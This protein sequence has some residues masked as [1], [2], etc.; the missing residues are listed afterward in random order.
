MKERKSISIDRKDLETLKPF[1]ASSGD[2]LS[3]AIR[4]LIEHYRSANRIS[5]VTGDQQR[6]M[7]LRNQI[8]EERIAVLVPVPLIKWLLRR[9]PGVPPLGTFRVLMEK[10]TR[11]LGKDSLSLRDYIE[12]VNAQSE[13]FGHR[14]QQH[15]EIAPDTKN[16]RISFEAEDADH[17]K[18]LVLNYSCMLAHH[19]L[20]LKTKKV[21]ESP[22]LIIVEFGT[23]DSE[24]EAYASVIANF[25]QNAVL[26][27]EV[28]DNVRFWR[29]AA[30][31]IRADRHDCVIISSDTLLALMKSRD[32]SDE[33]YRLISIIYCV[34]VEDCGYDELLGHI[35]DLCSANGLLTR[36]EH[37]QNE[38]KVYHKFGDAGV[39]QSVNDTIIRT[40]GTAGMRFM[41]KKEGKITILGRWALDTEP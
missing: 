6:L 15:V 36:I 35:N 20:K 33:L 18:G 31:I 9:M 28:S 2:N 24:D 29:T 10:Y 14:I 4:N 16:L 13:I 32:F 3:L 30:N 19:P 39:I 41:P 12:M 23:C 37:D 22:N 38:I 34:S 17:L 27:E 5:T 1:L 8:I 7:M 11:L 26:Y 25:G 40:L 21:D